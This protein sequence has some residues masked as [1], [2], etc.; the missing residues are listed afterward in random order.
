[1]N[2]KDIHQHRL[3]IFPWLED[4]PELG[5]DSFPWNESEMDNSWLC[6]H[7]EVVEL[8]KGWVALGWI[9]AEKLRVRPKTG[10]IAVKFNDGERDLW[11]H[12]IV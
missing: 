7:G 8:P 12:V 10:C 9:N 6:S 1:M 4:L 2:L 5:P 3:R 11:M